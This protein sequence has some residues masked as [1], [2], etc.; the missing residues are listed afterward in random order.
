MAATC[1]YSWHWHYLTEHYFTATC[2]ICDEDFSLKDSYSS[3]KRMKEH[4]LHI[5]SEIFVSGTNIEQHCIVK[6]WQVTCKYCPETFKCRTY[7]SE[8]TKK[9]LIFNHRVDETIANQMKQ[10]ISL[11]EC[12]YVADAYNNVKICNFL[13]C[14][15]MFEKTSSFILLKHLINNHRLYVPL[16]IIPQG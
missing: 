12:Y 13:E 16:H 9:H 7:L 6:N 3:A 10:W 8:K 2:S 15:N 1:R 5:H 14:R 11:S 4:L